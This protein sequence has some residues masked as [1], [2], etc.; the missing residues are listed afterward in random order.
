[1][2]EAV[3]ILIR[4]IQ[5][6][7]QFLTVALFDQFMAGELMHLQSVTALDQFGDLGELLGHL[8]GHL[9][10]QLHVVV[11]LLKPF[12]AFHVLRVV[13]IVIVDIHRGKLVE[14]LD[15]HTLTVGVDKAQRT[16]H[17][18]HAPFTAP[19]L[20]GLQQSGGDLEVVD[21]VEPAEAHLMTVPAPVGTI[22]DDGCHTT[23]DLLIPIR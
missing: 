11:I 1:M 10:L 7:E 14:T 20:Y 8:L 17:L 16:C 13:R 21:E 23:Y 2:T 9:D 19:V 5:E 3:Q 12:H 6:V 22:V 15:E 4:G 18:R